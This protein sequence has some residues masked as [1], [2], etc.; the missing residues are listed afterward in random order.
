MNYTLKKSLFRTIKCV[1][2]KTLDKNKLI[3]IGYVKINN[4]GEMKKDYIETYLGK[5]VN[6]ENETNVYLIKR[7]S[8]VYFLANTTIRKNQEIVL[9]K[10]DLILY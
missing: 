4:T 9:N 3:G 7:K 8:I 1:A 6:K 5:Y 2:S 10:K